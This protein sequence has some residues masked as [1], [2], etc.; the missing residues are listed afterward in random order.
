MYVGRVFLFAIVGVFLCLLECAGG[1]DGIC[2]CVFVCLSVGGKGIYVY[3][4]L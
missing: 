2:A 4:C 1:G 3:V